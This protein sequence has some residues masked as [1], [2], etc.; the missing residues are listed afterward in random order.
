MTTK[1]AISL[2][3]ELVADARRAVADGRSASVSA[4]VAEAIVER[5]RYEDLSELLDEM[6][7]EAG[8]PTDA[9]RAWARDALGLS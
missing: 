7:A 1:L 4:F 6:A 8:S 2:P 5:R 9:D 3:D